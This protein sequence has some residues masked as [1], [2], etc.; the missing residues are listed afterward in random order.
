MSASEFVKWGCVFVFCAM[1]GAAG[2]VAALRAQRRELA[3]RRRETLA[4]ID[5]RTEALRKTLRH[6]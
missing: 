6:D 2:P 4:W 1:A 3:R 5:F